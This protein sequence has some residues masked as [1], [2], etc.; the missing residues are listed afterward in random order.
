MRS[1]TAGLVEPELLRDT[2]VAIGEIFAVEID[3]LSP[4]LAQRDVGLVIHVR[5]TTVLATVQSLEHL[6]QQILFGPEV[7]VDQRLIDS[8][9]A[10]DSACRQ[11][12]ASVSSENLQC[13]MDDELPGRD[14]MLWRA[15]FVAII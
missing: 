13:R 3:R 6:E 14:V 15:G 9:F 11:A 7:V 5:L 12:T 8:R 4:F 10:G 1:P 2:H